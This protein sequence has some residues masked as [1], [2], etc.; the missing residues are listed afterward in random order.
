MPTITKVARS[1]VLVSVAGACSTAQAPAAVPST[2]P[3]A[4]DAALGARLDR[5]VEEALAQRRVVGVV[6]LV[7]RDGVLVHRRAA[8]LA[9]RE[10]GR[11]MTE[12]TRFRL[13]SM[14]KPVVS[15][16]VLALAERGVL[17]LDDP[18]ERWLPAFRP[19]LPNGE[20]AT[21]TLRQLLTH[22]SGLSYGF[23]E[24]PQGPLE[25][26]GVSNGLD[27]PG[28]DLAQNLARLQTVPLSF[29]PG[30]AWQYSM[31]TDVLGGVVERAF[32]APL[33]EAIRSLVAQPLGVDLPF[34]EAD[35]TQLATPYVSAQPEPERMAEPHD[36]PFGASYVRM[37]PRRALAAGSYPSG[38]AGILARA[39]DYL[40][41]LETLRSGGAP[42]LRAASVASMTHNQVGNLHVEL[43]GGEWGFGF[44]FAVLKK[45]AADSP[46]HAGSFM[47]GGV[48]GHHF[49][50][51]PE[52]RLSVVLLTNTALVGMM[53]EFPDAVTRAV[54]GEGS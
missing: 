41:F 21:I 8:G 51:D 6:L 19:P 29:E 36:V 4:S 48:Y 39:E 52:A 50:V 31:A 27:Q 33:P 35:E 11:A 25:R 15:T 3:T 20:P 2:V 46:L 1:L 38:G 18:V 42:L 9:D 24:P 37:S 7:A 22:T 40:R 30:S 49:F 10:T 47:W 23:W 43:E 28:L 53:G 16:A 32:G 13:A 44:G 26:A 12:Q 34:T 45:P 5:V 54:Y 14:T 17:H